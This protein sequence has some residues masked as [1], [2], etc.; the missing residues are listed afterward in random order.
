MFCIKVTDSDAF[1]ARFPCLSVLW[2]FILLSTIVVASNEVRKSA[3]DLFQSYEDK[4]EMAD[5][6]GLILTYDEVL[7]MSTYMSVSTNDPS[8]EQRY[9]AYEPLLE[10]VIRDAMLLDPDQNV[11]MTQEANARLVAMEQRA[12]DLVRGGRAAEGSLLLESTDY[13]QGKIDYIRGITDAM[14]RMEERINGV[15]DEKNNSMRN[16]IIAVVLLACITL[17]TGIV[18]VLSLMRWRTMLLSAQ[19]ERLQAHEELQRV[20]QHLEERI[21]ERTKEVQKQH[22]TLHEL[23]KQMLAVEEQERVRLSSILHDELQQILVT[24]Q[25]RLGA[26]ST[27]ELCVNKEEVQQVAQLVRTG[28]QTTRSLSSSLNPAAYSND[29][30]SALRHLSLRHQDSM[31]M[32][33]RIDVQDG[34]PQPAIETQQLLLRASSEMFFNITKHA[35][36]NQATLSLALTEANQ[37]RLVVADNGI[38]MSSLNPE[39]TSGLGLQSIRQRARWLG[40]ALEIEDVV[41][42]GTRITLTLPAGEMSMSS[43]PATLRRSAG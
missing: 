1:K 12:F 11:A 25:L 43:R 41:P 21:Q 35:Q 36:T 8:W 10:D 26:L 31:Q 33:I 6:K 2:F 23:T 5:L 42:Q 37:Y 16:S 9:R 24:A 39:I 40:G 7:T 29:I 28:I 14:L 20:N 34:L 30:F 17:L 19:A 4:A 32:Q 18:L 15:V 13:Q 38:G 3:I 22:D 27:D